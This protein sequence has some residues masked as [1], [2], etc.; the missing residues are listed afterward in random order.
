M[1][2]ILTVYLGW[3]IRSSICK[4]ERPTSVSTIQT[5]SYNTARGWLIF[6]VGKTKINLYSPRYTRGSLMKKAEKK[7]VNKIK[8][9]KFGW[10]KLGNCVTQR[11][12]RCIKNYVVFPA[13]ARGCLKISAEYFC[14]SLSDPFFIFQ[15]NFIFILAEGRTRANFYCVECLR[16]RINKVVLFL[17]NEFRFYELRIHVEHVLLRRLTIN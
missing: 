2:K 7:K 6:L 4:F 14:S 10:T 3:S 8:R 13:E 12:L 16:N 5:S 11:F 1:H 9:T 15:K 17:I